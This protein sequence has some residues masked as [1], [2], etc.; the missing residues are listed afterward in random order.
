MKMAVWGY[1]L[2]I[3]GITG[4]LL[5]N[6]FGNI[7][8]TDEQNYYLLKEI[9][10][11]SMYD[12]IDFAAY[13]LG[14]NYDGE[15]PGVIKIEK[16]KFIES[17]VRR[18]AESTGKTRHYKISFLEIIEEPPKVSI[19][20]ESKED[21]NFF[22]AFKPNNK[23]FNFDSEE[24]FDIM[25]KIDAILETRAEYRDVMKKEGKGE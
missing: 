10:E 6:V 12:S 9:T 13:R 3:L 15:N 7:S 8:T 24:D 4:I 2:M 22:R 16:E 1:F 21:Y 18:F 14:L 20:L 5:I 23:E 11:A 17:F 25:N 19:R